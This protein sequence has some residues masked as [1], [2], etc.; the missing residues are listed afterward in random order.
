LGAIL[1][2]PPLANHGI[3]ALLTD[4]FLTTFF[5]LLLGTPIAFLAL[6][7]KGYLAPLGLVALTLVLAQIIAVTGFGHYFPWSVPGLFS[8]AGGDYKAQLDAVSY[9]LLI[10]TSLAGYCATRLY[11]QYADQMA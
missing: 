2:L 4:Y 5:T 8:G 6:W 10:A 9:G 11:W 3:G 1:H 7:G